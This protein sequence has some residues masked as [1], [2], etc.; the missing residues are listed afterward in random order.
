MH[1]PVPGWFQQTHVPAPIEL[2]A[3]YAQQSA[4]VH[5]V[6]DG[7]YPLPP[8]SAHAQPESEV[9][10]LTT[11]QLQLDDVAQHPAGA[12]S[13]DDEHPLPSSAL[14]GVHVQL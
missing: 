9:V 8:T 6:A 14:P 5:D 3:S 10:Q 13:D 2:L 7:V 4:P 12:A 1:P 11:S